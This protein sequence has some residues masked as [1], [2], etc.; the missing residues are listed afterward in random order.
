MQFL[1]FACKVCVFFFQ[2]FDGH[3]GIK[4]LQRRL[5]IRLSKLVMIVY[6]QSWKEYF[7]ICVFHFSKI[8]YF[9]R[10]HEQATAKLGLH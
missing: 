4:N 1:N 2:L 6:I 8:I 7:S 10:E 5:G 9:P 3:S